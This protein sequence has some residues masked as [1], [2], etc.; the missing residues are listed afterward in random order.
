MSRRAT[1]A[2]L[3]LLNAGLLLGPISF[4]CNLNPASAD[5]VG[6]LLDELD[7]LDVDIDFDD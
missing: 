5:A 7:G 4:K 3:T 1:L 2:L 6:E